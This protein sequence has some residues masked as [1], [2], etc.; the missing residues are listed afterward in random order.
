[1]LVLW[2]SL[3]GL[4][5]WLAGVRPAASRIGPAGALVLAAVATM[6]FLSPGNTGPTQAGQGDGVAIEVA[7][8]NAFASVVISVVEPPRLAI[9]VPI[10]SIIVLRPDETTSL[11]AASYDQYGG[12]LVNLSYKWR[13]ITPAIGTITSSGVFHAG[14]REGSFPGALAV[15][16]TPPPGFGLETVQGSVDVIIRREERESLPSSIRLFPA[17]AE[18]ELGRTAYLTALGMDSAG[19]LLPGGQSRWEMVDNQA[20]SITTAGRFTAEAKPG[21]Y[22]KAI[23]VTLPTGLGDEG[24]STYMDV[25][26]LEAT[27]AASSIRLSILPQTVNLRPGQSMTFSAVALDLRDG[28]RL[29][30]IQ[31]R[32]L[33]LDPTAG[34]VSKDGRFQASEQPGF[35]RDA[36]QASITLLAPDGDTAETMTVQATVSI[37]DTSGTDLD[38]SLVDAT[39]IELSENQL[40]QISIFPRRVVLSPGASTKLGIVGVDYY[41]RFLSGFIVRWQLDA[42]LGEILPSSVVIAG[43]SPG[44]YPGAVRGHVT[45]ETNGR[46]MT[47]EVSADLVIRGPLAAVTIEPTFATVSPGAWVQFEAKGRDANGTLLPEV[48]FRW[49]VVDERAGS[50]DAVGSFVASQQQGTYQDVVKV[51]AVQHLRLP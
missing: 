24:I 18:L 10:P 40:D 15:E 34:T 13:L 7:D 2:G 41:E 26:V 6:L 44:I 27:S 28:Q 3:A 30:G 14:I 22:P 42:Q 21:Y 33:T 36:I 5:R 38:T 47:G 11:T 51:V 20:G 12:Q 19:T 1:M 39:A 16:S 31:V 17:M 23:L 32:W 35:Y 50:I 29:E 46:V 4:G 45:M 8:A 37:P 25:L 43:E 9:V 48:N 49:S